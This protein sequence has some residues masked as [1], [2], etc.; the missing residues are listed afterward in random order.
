V[1]RRE[2]S[3][4]TI[5][6]EDR[7]ALTDSLR[8]LLADKSAEADVRRVMETPSGYDPAL[9]RALAEMGI[10]GLVIAEAYGGVGAG[11]VELEL[12]TEETGAALLCA[13]LI[14]TVL[15]AGLVQALADE[16]AERRLLPEI[17]K[18][19]KVATVALAGARGGWAR[20][21]VAVDARSANGGW[22]LEG[23]ASFVT[24]GQSADVI[25]VAARAGG[26]I[27]VF[28]VAGGAA[29]LSIQPLP[30]FDHT[31]RLANLTFAGVP[32]MRLGRGEAWPAIET[33]LDLARVALAGEQAGG[34][35]RALEITVDYAKTRV[36]FG[37]LIGSFQAIKHM[38]ANLLL[39]SESAIS[40][41]R[42]AAKA[43]ADGAPT[44]RAQISLAAFAC[45][46]AFSQVTADAI[47]MHGGIA[48][49]WTHPAHLY[50]RRARADA[51]LFGPPAH[52]RERFLAELGA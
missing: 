32:A 51:Q 41:A 44:A 22:R 24:D 52:Y 35:K 49:T 38:A 9:W 10:A 2:A 28:E 45:A 26:E 27:G 23:T 1:T 36:Q 18:G 42:A 3:I 50:L 4:S 29:G 7:T 40:A 37:R 47:Q 39:E 30:T 34:A 19:A 43:L 46:E 17:A 12:V 20:Q 31:L 21:D 5:T 11:P 14:S 16:L 33:A 48:F 13:P 6:A 15:A 25:L 8:R